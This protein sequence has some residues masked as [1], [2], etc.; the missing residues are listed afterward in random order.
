MFGGEK[1]MLLFFYQLNGEFMFKTL[2]F[3][4]KIGNPN[5]GYNNY[6]DYNK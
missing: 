3:L 6:Q 1:R 2:Y 4:S 5:T